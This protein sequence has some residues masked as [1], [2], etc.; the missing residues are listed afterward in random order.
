M[1][2]CKTGDTV[3]QPGSDVR[4]VALGPLSPHLGIYKWSLSMVMSIMH[5]GTGIFLHFALL[6]FMWMFIGNVLAPDCGLV[7][8]LDSLLIGPLGKALLMATSF[9]TFYHLLAGIRHLVFDLGVGLDLT[10]SRMSGL[11]V[12]AGSLLLTAASGF[13]ILGY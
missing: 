13:F 12:L 8:T 4:G 1:D 6:F 9:A 2:N 11:F 5:R 10:T 3:N 7:D